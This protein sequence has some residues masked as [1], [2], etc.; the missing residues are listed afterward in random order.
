[1]VYYFIFPQAFVFFISFQTEGADGAIATE[2]LPKM[3]EYL[4]LVLKLIFAFGICFQLP[5]MLTLMGRVGMVTSSG[6]RAKRKYAIVIVL[7]AASALTPPDLFSQIGLGVPMMFLYEISIF[8]GKMAEKKR[9]EKQAEEEA[10][11]ARLDAILAAD[12]DTE[13][14]DFNYGR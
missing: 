9:A 14:T 11:M 3:N 8:L 13:E 7:I 10:E 4:S 2:L 5:V 6:L 12:D 1:M